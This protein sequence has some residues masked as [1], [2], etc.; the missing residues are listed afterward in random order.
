[1]C[2]LTALQISVLVVT[3]ATVLLP[4]CQIYMDKYGDLRNAP[5]D[6]W[7]RMQRDADDDSAWE[8]KFY[9]CWVCGYEA[10]LKCYKDYPPPS[11]GMLWPCC[12]YGQNLATFI[13]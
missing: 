7:A 9:Y 6:M 12:R 4:S 2:E 8:I 5:P 1:M 11:D 10:R 3:S 13:E